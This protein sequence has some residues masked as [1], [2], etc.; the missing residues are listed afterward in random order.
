MEAKTKYSTQ[1]DSVVSNTKGI[2][3]V[4]FP[5]IYTLLSHYIIAK[6]SLSNLSALL[7]KLSTNSAQTQHSLNIY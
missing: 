1:D 6:H 7:L 4:G 5:Q 3:L 2:I